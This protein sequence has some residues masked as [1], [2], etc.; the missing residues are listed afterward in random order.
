MRLFQERYIF[1]LRVMRAR[2]YF[3][4]ST[5]IE[6]VKRQEKYNR[7]L[8][9]LPRTGLTG[10]DMGA[11]QKEYRYFRLKTNL[12]QVII[13]RDGTGRSRGRHFGPKHG[14]QEMVDP[15]LQLLPLQDIP[16][17]NVFVFQKAT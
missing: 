6:N 1:T 14:F 15:F 17:G 12:A 4:Q 16:K 2:H 3:F 5:L 10:T 8:Q 9:E 13:R 11:F 7:A